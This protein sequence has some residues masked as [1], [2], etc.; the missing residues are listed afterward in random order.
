MYIS[1]AIASAEEVVLRSIPTYLPLLG[2]VT[3]VTVVY[4]SPLELV[5]SSSSTSAPA[6]FAVCNSP[7]VVKSSPNAR[8][9]LDHSAFCFVLD[10]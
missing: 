10:K 9:M 2:L 7:A 8:V 6:N 4:F 3:L 1:V 5:L